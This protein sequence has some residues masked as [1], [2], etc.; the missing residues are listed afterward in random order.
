MIWYFM[1][2]ANAKNNCIKFNVAIALNLHGTDLFW[3]EFYNRVDFEY[4]T[5][6]KASLT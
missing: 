4:T 5:Y 3:L 2:R 1:V 6:D